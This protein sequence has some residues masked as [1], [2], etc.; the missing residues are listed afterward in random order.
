MG[1]FYHLQAK[2]HYTAGEIEVLWVWTHKYGI[3]L[4]KT[5]AQACRIDERAGTDFWA[6][7]IAKEMRN[8]MPQPLNSLTTTRFRK[9]TAI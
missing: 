4:P 2:S 1:P 3:E 7:A 9:V 6:K 5:I 8:V